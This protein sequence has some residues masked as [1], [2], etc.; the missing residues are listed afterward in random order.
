MAPQMLRGIP[1]GAPKPERGILVVIVNYAP[2]KPG[3]RTV[4][5]TPQ[6]FVEVLKSTGDLAKA[7]DAAKKGCESTRLRGWR[8]A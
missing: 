5:D 6:P 3:D 4:V 1:L 8:R 2:A 7:V